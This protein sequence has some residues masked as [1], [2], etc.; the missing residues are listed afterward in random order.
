MLSVPTTEMKNYTD[1]EVLQRLLS[2]KGG[3]D[4][5]GFLHTWK[6]SCN[7]ALKSRQQ[8]VS[9]LKFEFILL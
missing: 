1:E 7:T 3:C 4:W 2:K 8:T 9:N 6:S 5:G